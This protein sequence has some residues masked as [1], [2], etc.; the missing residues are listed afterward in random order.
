MPKQRGQKISRSILL[1]LDQAVDNRLDLRSLPY[2]LSKFSKHLFP[3]ERRYSRPQVK[4]ALLHLLKSGLLQLVEDGE[5][6]VAVTLTP[7]GKERAHALRVDTLVIRK[8]K[9]WDGKWRMIVF[10]IPESKRKIRD[11]LRHRLASLN[12]FKLQDSIW[13]YPYD[14]RHAISFLAD[15]Y[16]LHGHLHFAIV[17]VFDQEDE[18]R[19]HYGIREHALPYEGQGK[20]QRTF[21]IP[22]LE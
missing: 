2:R 16:G 17:D 13:I 12:F 15:H 19:R 14:C 5:G 7:R 8:P 20:R 21:D 3:E 1:L 22:I 6:T 18:A 9:Y 10:D 11:A 4:R